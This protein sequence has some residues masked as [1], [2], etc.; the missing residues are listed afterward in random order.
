MFNSLHQGK[1]KVTTVHT[2]LVLVYQKDGQ[3]KCAHYFHWCFVASATGF[4][5]LL[6]MS[7][8]VPVEESFQRRSAVELF[9]TSEA[10]RS[11][12]G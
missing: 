10:R 5:S 12:F 4:P 8:N 9:G 2:N 3:K 1:V 11:S 6:C 7:D